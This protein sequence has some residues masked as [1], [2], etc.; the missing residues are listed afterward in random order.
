MLSTLEDARA[1]LYAFQKE[2]NLLDKPLSGETDHSV[3]DDTKRIWA[4]SS[5]FSCFF[6]VQLTLE[7]KIHKQNQK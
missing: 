5:Q 2:L 1:Y 6:S 4:V 7:S 3:W